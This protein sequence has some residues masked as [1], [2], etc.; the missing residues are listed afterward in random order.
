[1]YQ[2]G[3]SEIWM[4]EE[5][6]SKEEAIKAA[7]KEFKNDKSL[8]GLN[9]YVGQ[10]E[11]VSV[12]GIDVD[13]LLENIAE[14]T[15]CEIGEVGEDYLMDVSKEEQEELEEKL[16]KVLFEWIEKYNYNPNFFKIVNIEQ[17]FEIE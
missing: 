15:T 16:N 13:L 3:E 17:V 14:N 1:M 5:F 12:S 6:K 2:F 4:G 11:S 9:L 7:E 10:Q 8:R